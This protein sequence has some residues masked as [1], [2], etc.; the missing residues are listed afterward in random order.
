MMFINKEQHADNSAKYFLSKEVLSEY[1]V[2]NIP[3]LRSVGL[4]VSELTGNKIKMSAPL[5]DN[6]N[7]YGSA[8][9]GSI[10]TLGIVAGWAILTYK[11]KEEKVPTTLVIKSSHTEYVRP[12]KNDFHAEVEIDNNDWEKLK[13]KFAEKGKAGIEVTAK[14][15]SDGNVCAEQKSVYVCIKPKS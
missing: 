3:I 4:D 7:H 6:R 8:F 2:T 10:A 12:V 15:I 5:F 13:T 1:I 11:V 9:G 14:I